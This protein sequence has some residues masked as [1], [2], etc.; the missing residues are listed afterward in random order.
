MTSFEVWIA[1]NRSLSAPT[2]EFTQAVGVRCTVV[3]GC[4]CTPLARCFTITKAIECGRDFDV[5]LLMDDDMGVRRIEDV[6]QLVEAAAKLQRPVS[7]VYIGKTGQVM[8][9]ELTSGSGPWQE[10]RWLTGLGCFAVPMS[11]LRDLAAMS[12]VLALELGEFYA[13]TWAG[14]GNTD[15]GERKWFSEDYRLSKRLGGVTLAPISFGHQKPT[16]L[17]PDEASI[18]RL[19][20]GHTFLPLTKESQ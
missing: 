2:H 14:P 11:L 8:A 19:A 7:G 9:T 15:D 10:R 4:S 3:E 13:V 18:Q 1:S 16:L 5:A 20:Q 12:E 17:Y 6:H